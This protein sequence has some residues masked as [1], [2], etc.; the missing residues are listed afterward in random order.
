MGTKVFINLPV[1]NLPK[2]K[3]FFEALG[4][5]FNPQFTDDN[6]AC[7][8]ISEENFAMLLTR[9]YYSTFTAKQIPDADKTVQ[10]LIAL[11]LE[12]RSK[13][14]A[15]ADAA[16]ANGAT[17]GGEPKDHG[18]MYIRQFSDL[19]GHTSEVSWFNPTALQQ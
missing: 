4:F 19:D 12:D 9:E 7:M 18:F 17:S 3:A 6:A 5:S 16:L 13:A 1:A 14:D 8:V 10:V 15:V 2:S 11:G